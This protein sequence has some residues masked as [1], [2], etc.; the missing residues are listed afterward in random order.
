MSS[1]SPDRDSLPFGWFLVGASARNIRRNPLRSSMRAL[2]IAQLAI[3]FIAAVAMK[4]VYLDGILQSGQ[5]T[6]PFAVA[7]LLLMVPLSFAFKQS[8]LNDQR[9]LLQP[10]LEF[11]RIIGIIALS[12]LV[13]VGV[14]YLAKF[15]HYYSRAWLL[16]WFLTTVG[17][18]ILV[19]SLT[20]RRLKRLHDAGALRRRVALYGQ[21]SHVMAIREQ[22][23]RDNPGVDVTAVFTQAAGL[24]DGA[25]CSELGHLRSAMQAGEYDQVIIGLPDTERTKIRAAVTGL[26]PYTQE[27]LLLSDLR[28]RKMPRHG[29][30]SVGK[31]RADVISPVS[32][33]E[34]N[35]SLKRASD[36]LMAGILLVAVAPLLLVIAIAIKLDSRGDVFFRQR[37]HG[38]NNRVF[39]IFKFRTMSVAEDGD[40]VT[41]AARNDSR[42]TRVG[43]ILRKT[44]LDELPQLLNVLRGEMSIV[45]PRPHALAHEQ[46]FEASLDMFSRRRRVLP[47]IT[48]WAQVNGFRG[49]TKT[50]E[51][52]EGRMTCDLYYVDNWSIWLDLEILVR[53][54]LTVF[55][56]AH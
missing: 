2:G 25:R 40:V 7:G 11:G 29:V 13:L 42:V 6:L 37:R 5:S 1:V 12:F 48:G 22:L 41:Q 33:A 39:R 36:V 4:L 52:I 56:G 9:A 24:E 46:S 51:D 8:G 10:T 19:R 27:L 23:E 53:T 55:R 49:E 18:V 28:Q 47:G 30:A 50:L 34:Q 44:S 31:L 15:T 35:Q 45:G 21:S 38:K 20:S 14:L 43:R 3:A 32:Q 26:A 16:L 17:G 54:V